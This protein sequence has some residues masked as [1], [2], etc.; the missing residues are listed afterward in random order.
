MDDLTIEYLTS[1]LCIGEQEAH[2]PS[3]SPEYQRLYTDFLSEGLIFAYE[4]PH[5][6]TNKNQ[7][8]HWKAAL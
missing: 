1:L 8:W 3:G 6:K 4:Q 5:H 7:Q 2:R